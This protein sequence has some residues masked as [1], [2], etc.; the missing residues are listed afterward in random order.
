M[1]RILVLNDGNY[2]IKFDVVFFSNKI[3]MM[4]MTTMK[5]LWTKRD[6]VMEMCGIGK[7]I[8]MVK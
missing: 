2:G 4:I 5:I 1:Y 8:L 3:R 6:I 7:R